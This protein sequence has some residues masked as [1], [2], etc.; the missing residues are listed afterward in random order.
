MER[1]DLYASAN[2]DAVFE[3]YRAD[4]DWR[5]TYG[6]LRRSYWHVTS[7]TN[8]N[9]ILAAG[10]I[11]PSGKASGLSSRFK[12]TNFAYQRVC[13]ALFDFLS[14]T[15]EECIES[16]CHAWDIMVLSGDERAVL[17]ELSRDDL[18]GSVLPNSTAGHGLNYVKHLEVWYPTPIPASAFVAAYLLPRGKV[19]GEFN[20]TKIDPL[21]R[22]EP[23]PHIPEDPLGWLPLEV[24]QGLFSPPEQVQEDP[25]EAMIAEILK[26][27]PATGGRPQPDRASPL[28]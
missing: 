23:I 14:P 28:D 2:R 17:I 1:F 5:R 3:A 4:P 19:F 27:A 21:Q 6:F 20:Y 9:S 12:E 25:I 22:V 26:Q 11:R 24:R 8:W 16:W 13:V 7:P 18:S 15:E 10:E